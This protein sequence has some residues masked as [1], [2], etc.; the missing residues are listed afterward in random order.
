MTEQERSY[1]DILEPHWSDL[2]NYTDASDWLRIMEV[3]PQPIILLYAAHFSQSE[4]CNGG[5][6]QFFQNS[7]GVFAPEAV[8]GYRAIGMPHLADVVSRAMSSLGSEYPRDRQRRWDALQIASKRT[9]EE[10][11]TI[12][13]NAKH[14]ATAERQASQPPS[15]DELEA[16]FFQLIRSEGG[17]F[18]SAADAYALATEPTLVWPIPSP[19]PTPR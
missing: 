7:S 17:G 10:L 15:F 2:G 14:P 3:F 18:D 11:E 1:W 9:P 5:F 12:R 8:E 19:N 4:I 16:Q 6:L 13:K